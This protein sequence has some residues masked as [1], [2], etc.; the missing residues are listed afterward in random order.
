MT[1]GELDKG[2][3]GPHATLGMTG[4][5]ITPA[6]FLPQGQNQAQWAGGRGQVSAGHL[7]RARPFS[8]LLNPLLGRW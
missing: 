2:S 8:R 5:E 6:L 1:H 3:L 4:R 7:P